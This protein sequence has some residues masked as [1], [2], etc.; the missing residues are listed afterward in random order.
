MGLQKHTVRIEWMGLEPEHKANCALTQELEFVEASEPILDRLLLN[1]GPRHTSC[2]CPKAGAHVDLPASGVVPKD[3]HTFNWGGMGGWFE[4]PRKHVGTPCVPGVSMKLRALV[5]WDSHHE[6]RIG[7]II[8]SAPRRQ[9]F[10]LRKYFLYVDPLHCTVA[11]TATLL[12]PMC[13]APSVLLTRY[14]DDK[15]VAFRNILHEVLYVATAFLMSLQEALNQI[16]NPLESESN[17][18]TKIRHFLPKFDRP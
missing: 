15:F 1:T 3:V 5:P 13:N 9:H 11:K 4:Q 16:T 14:M 17:L 10:F 8:Q 18:I 2:H 6:G 12:A 7:H